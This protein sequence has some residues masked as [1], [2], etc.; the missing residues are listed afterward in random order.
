M[1]SSHKNLYAL[2]DD[3]A[4]YHGYLR[5]RRGKRKYPSTLAFE[6][7]LGPNLAQLADELRMHTYQVSPYRRFYVHEP[8][9]REISA[10]AFRDRVVQHAVYAIINPIFDRAFIHDSYGCRVGKGTHRASLRTQH[11][12]RGSRAGSYTLQLDIRKYYYSVNRAILRTLIERKIRDVAFVDLMMQFT[13]TESPVGLPIGNLLSQLFALIYLDAFDQYVKRELKIKQYVRYVDDSI[14]FNLE[15]DQAY[16][17]RHQIQQWLDEQLSLQLSRFTIAPTARGVNFVGFRTWRRYRLIR[18]HSLYHF[19]R[20]LKRQDI[21]S[22]NAIM[23]NAMGTSSLQH[24]Q[25]RVY[26][27]NPF[28]LHRLAHW[29]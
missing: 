5:A 16:A 27:E 3:E 2:I 14:L 22:L 13:E 24:L 18:K 9:T 25:Q 6:R 21:P 7:M 8:K 26:D 23:G 4:L 28:I 17:L 10:P 15:R 19:S 11:F 20:S 12:L 29:I 1:P